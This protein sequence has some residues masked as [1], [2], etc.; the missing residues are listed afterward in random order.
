MLSFFKNLLGWPSQ[1]IEIYFYLGKH[2]VS[3][4][5][6]EVLNCCF[7]LDSFFDAKLGYATLYIL[8]NSGSQSFQALITFWY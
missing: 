2:F 7:S 5:V 3:K 4:C 8:R 1:I 6:T